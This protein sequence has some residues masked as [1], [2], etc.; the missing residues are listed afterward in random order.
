MLVAGNIFRDSHGYMFN[1]FAIFMVA[2]CIFTRDRF[3]FTDMTLQF[4]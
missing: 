1:H 4:C 2:L 3:N